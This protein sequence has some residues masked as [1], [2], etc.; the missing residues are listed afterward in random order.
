MKHGNRIRKGRRFQRSI[1][2]LAMPLMNLWIIQQ[3]R[4]GILPWQNLREELGISFEQCVDRLG[5]LTRYPTDDPLLPNA[6]LRL[7]VIRA[8][9]LD[10]A[11]VQV[12]PT[13][14]LASG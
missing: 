10:Q 12:W 1:V 11:L 4:R 6:G 9:S 14:C 13:R 3:R 7:F 2:P 8:P 5:H